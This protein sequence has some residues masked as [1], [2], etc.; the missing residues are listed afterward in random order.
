MSVEPGARGKNFTYFIGIDVSKHTL[1]YA[2]MQG[3]ELRFHEVGNNESVAIAAFLAVLKS[4]PKFA[5]SKAVFCLEHSGFYGNHL[6]QCLKKRKANIVLENALQI[7]NSLGLIRGKYDKIDAI[8]I[9]RYVYK[10]RDELRLWSPKRPEVERL[11][12]LFTLRNRIINVQKGLKMPLKEQASFIRNGLQQQTATLCQSSLVALHRDRE[13]VD[14]AIDELISSDAHLNRLYQ[15]ITSVPCIGRI[16]AIQLILSTNEYRD[17]T[18]PKKFA[19][20]CGVAPFRKE[21]GLAKGKSK[22]S[23]IANKQVK[24]LLHVCALNAIRFDEEIKQ[25]FER[26][27]VMDGKPKMAALNAVR[28]KLILRAFACLK[29]NRSYEK[30]RAVL[31]IQQQVN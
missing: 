2:V 5:M 17:I 21:S 6:L 14:Q 9:A 12:L 27:T 19:C 25:Y 8:R 13:E 30:D 15:Q 16:T 24:A 4:Q 28:Y 7:R 18:D 20:Y 29:Q 22:V 1:D 11:S 26:K 10:C 23:S 3:K 31:K